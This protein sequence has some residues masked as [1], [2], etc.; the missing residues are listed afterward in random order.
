MNHS[1]FDRGV[2]SMGSSIQNLKGSLLKLAG[3][4]GLAFGVGAIINFGKES[5]KAASELNNAWIG[6]QSIV[7]G[8]GR[9]FGK[10]K[11]FIEEYISDGLVPLENAVA[12]YKNLAARGY[13]DKQIR[14]LM[15]ALKDSASFGRQ[16]S[17]ALGEAIQT[18]T[19]GL[20]NENSILVDNAGVTKN[21]SIMW[22]EYAKSI[23]VGERS[24]TLAQRRQAEVNGILE[25][26]R[27]QAGDAAKL[28]NTYSGQVAM[29]GFNFQQ[30]KVQ[31]GNAIMPVVQAVLPGI[32]AIIAALLK[33]AKVF[34]KVTAL[35]FGKA[36]AGTVGQV[37]AN[38]EIT[39]SG[40]AA[41]DATDKLADSTAGAGSA[42]KKAAKDMKGILAGFDEL[43]IL[44]DKA[45]GSLSGAAGGIGAGEID[46]DIPEFDIG[47]DAAEDAEEAFKSL[48]EI[49]KDTLGSMLTGITRLKEVFLDF[50]ESFNNFNQTLYDAFKFDGVLE[51]VEWLGRRLADA[52]N[53]LV[54]AID[55]QLWGQR[56]GAGLNLGLQFLTEFIYTFDWINLGK[57]LAEFING[58][59]YEVDWYDFGRLLWAKFKIGLET[60]AGFLTGLDMP[61][62]AKAAS[63]IIMGF[64]DEMKNTIAKIDWAEIGRQVARFL[65]N[66]DWMGML[67]SALGAIKA[68]VL[69]GFDFLVGVIEQGSPGLLAAV[70]L[71][72]GA[73]GV[74]FATDVVPKIVNIANA[75]QSFFKKIKDISVLLK[76]EMANLSGAINA[77]FG[78]GS[79]LAGI[80]MVVGGAVLA[81]TNFFSM[82]QNGFSLANEVL[83]LLGI[84]IT[85]LGAII[86][87]VSTPVAAAIAGIVAV[88]GTLAAVFPDVVAAVITSWDT[89]RQT[90]VDS[91]Q[92]IVDVVSSIQTSIQEWFDQMRAGWENYIQPVLQNIIDKFNEVVQQHIAPLIEQIL[93][94]IGNISEVVKIL[95]ETILSPFVSWLIGVMGPKIG[96]TLEFIGSVFLTTIGVISDL[97]TGLLQTLNGLIKFLT[98]VFTGDWEKA[99]NGIRNTVDGAITFV[100]GIIDGFVENLK[101]AVNWLKN[102][103]GLSN[104]TAR[105]KSPSGYNTIH[106]YSQVYTIGRAENV[107]KSAPLPRLANGAVIPPNQQFAAI[108]GDQRKGY[109]IEAPADLIYQMVA[110]GIRDSGAALNGG[111]NRPITVILQVD[112]RELGRV[113]YEVNTQETQ[114]VGVRLAR[115]TT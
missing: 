31:I 83:M 67:A 9:S 54:N 68:A 75:F 13:D 16:S 97:I 91:L 86:L 33:L 49:F 96:A 2:H 30:L 58:L 24:L 22:R 26:T 47:N 106:K 34:A 85:A 69:A 12:A 23:G 7:E 57:K 76:Y 29:L 38:E 110:K 65:S 4:V 103:L 20:K 56:L 36:N 112:R 35:L 111:G 114:R 104:E 88:A 82:L 1:Q 115:G 3:A 50:A 45:S 8:Q 28:V 63:S 108:L 61:A 18:A 51:R 78:P 60:F 17:Y 84:A 41:A 62:L 55:W 52:F 27:F 6:L 64:F 93:K 46:A 90:F 53:A 109:N 107:L 72:A 42:S 71:V 79:T 89:L 87:G 32:N 98:G 77:V 59:V 74:K 43:N 44:A 94:L 66:I 100:S 11:S 92:P 113:V 40:L 105:V 5:V 95:W 10:A 21:V 102:F 15:L 25:E 73:M 81:F 48:G 37:S 99:F 14:Q 19:E 70:S 101:S 39:S 80:A